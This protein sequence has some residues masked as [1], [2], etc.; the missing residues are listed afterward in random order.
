MS[1]QRMSDMKGAF[2]AQSQK[3]EDLK[4]A[5]ISGDQR[6]CIEEI[7]GIGRDLIREPESIEIEHIQNPNETK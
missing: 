5:K 3:M 2:D 4:N 6:G 7:M 1:K